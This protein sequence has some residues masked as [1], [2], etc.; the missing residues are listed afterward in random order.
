MTCRTEAVTGSLDPEWNETHE[1]SWC[2]GE[3]LEFTVYDQGPTGSKTEGA[4]TVP[5]D[6]FYPQGFSGELQLYGQASAAKL[7][8]QI[9]L[10]MAKSPP[11][12]N[13]SPSATE[14]APRVTWQNS[15]ILFYLFIF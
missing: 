3:A 6:G 5:S 9:R 8:V 14:E 4:A 10:Q 13:M 7:H 15:R 2:E 12:P 1:L 11:S